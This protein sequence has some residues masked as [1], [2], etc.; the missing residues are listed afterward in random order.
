MLVAVQ[1]SCTYADLEDGG[2]LFS[3]ASIDGLSFC[4]TCGT[5]CRRCFANHF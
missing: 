5:I 1:E 4:P 2:G 3:Q